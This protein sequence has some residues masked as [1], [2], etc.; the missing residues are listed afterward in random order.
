V[1]NGYAG[2][3]IAAL[4]QSRLSRPNIVFILSDDQGAWALGCARNREVRT[5][6]LDRLAETG[7][8]V[9]ELKHL[10]W[11][12]VAM[13]GPHPVLRKDLKKRDV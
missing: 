3:R 5:P 11:A 8:R 1:L 9:G 7:M 2:R 13:D 10:T 6:N 4:S 12:D